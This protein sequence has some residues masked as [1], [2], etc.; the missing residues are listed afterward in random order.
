MAAA[1]H[2]RKQSANL[3]VDKDL[4]REARELQVN[5]S[6]VFEERLRDVI[7]EKRQQRW[8][9]ENAEGF[10]AY[11]RLVEKHGIFNEEEREW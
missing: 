10:S 8:L 6:Q 11:E 2:R 3:S 5:L 4:L 9:K 7:R 1:H